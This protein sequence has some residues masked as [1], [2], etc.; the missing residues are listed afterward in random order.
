M[1]LIITQSCRLFH[2]RNADTS[3]MGELPDKSGFYTASRRFFKAPGLVYVT[4]PETAPMNRC[5][6]SQVI[7]VYDIK[8]IKGKQ[9]P[10]YLHP[11]SREQDD[12]QEKDEIKVKHL[13]NTGLR[14]ICVLLTLQVLLFAGHAAAEEGG[15]PAAPEETPVPQEDAARC[16]HPPNRFLKKRKELYNNPKLQK[17]D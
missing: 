16:S 3:L 14:M 6:G 9:L 13:L 11:C 7:S 2:T 5:C 1:F 4:L 12:A 17:T 8:P 15:R 10:L